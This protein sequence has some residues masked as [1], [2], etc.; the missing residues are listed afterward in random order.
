MRSALY[1][2]SLA[3]IVTLGVSVATAQSDR[4]TIA[5]TVKDTTPAGVTTATGSFNVSVGDN[6]APTSSIAASDVTSAG[7]AT[8]SFT[9]TYNDDVAIDTTSITLAN[10]SVTGPVGPREAGAF[11]AELARHGTTT[12]VMLTAAG[13]G[14]AAPPTPRVTASAAAE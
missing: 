8:Y 6:T 13:R 14:T 7:G 3:L 12:A 2:F 5:G 1:V 11:F 9:V 10:V 4:G